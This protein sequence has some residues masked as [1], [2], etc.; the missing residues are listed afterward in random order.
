MEGSTKMKT[1][2]FSLVLVISLIGIYTGTAYSQKKSMPQKGFLKARLIEKLNLTDE[3]KSKIEDLRITH[4]E[5]MIDLKA[6]LE[7]KILALK[8]L[9]VKGNIDRN[10]VIAAVK[11]INQAKDEIALARANNIM[12]IYETLT[13]DQQKILRDNLGSFMKFGGGRNSMWGRGNGNGPD[14]EGFMRMHR[15][16]Q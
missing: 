3:Q 16:M 5:K 1:K 14:G 13:P 8:E 6:N 9:R 11:D 10:S 12:D 15:M 2:I 4:Q 7:K